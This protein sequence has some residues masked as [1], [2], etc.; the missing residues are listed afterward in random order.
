MVDFVGANQTL[1][2]HLTGIELLLLILILPDL[3]ARC[4][5]GGVSGPNIT[6]EDIFQLPPYDV[7]PSANAW[8]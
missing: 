7:V 5:D 1:L 4:Y 8:Y 6:S 3:R 2:V